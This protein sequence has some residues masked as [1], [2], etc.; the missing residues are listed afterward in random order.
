MIY[1]LN[2]GSKLAESNENYQSTDLNAIPTLYVWFDINLKYVSMQVLLIA[3]QQ[4][5]RSVHLWQ[6]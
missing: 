4:A 2:L 1:N 5:G 6:M 3:T